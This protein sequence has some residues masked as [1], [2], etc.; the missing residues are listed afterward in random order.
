MK[1]S[2]ISKQL[3]K[4]LMIINGVSIKPIATIACLPVAIPPATSTPLK[5]L[6][7]LGV[8]FAMDFI[9]GIG[10][11]Y[12]ESKKSTTSA[13]RTNNNYFL[14]SSK[15]RLSIVKF[16][17]YGLAVITARSIEWAFIPGE[18]SPNDNLNKMTLTTIVIG[19]CCG[20]EIYSIFFENIKRMGFDI[21]QKIKTI[22]KEGWRFYKYLKN[23]RTE[24]N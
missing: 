4:P 16:I 20:I 23:E 24:D 9:T 8:F 18:F 14:T 10:A 15:F 19:I 1:L 11:S 12:V 2:T 3:E 7:L 17:T 6:I 13:Y 22:S 21:I 5:A